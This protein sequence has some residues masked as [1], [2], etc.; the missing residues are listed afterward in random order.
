MELQ[1]FSKRIAITGALLILTIKYLLRPHWSFPEPVGF[2]LGIAPNLIASFLL[3]FF[4]CWLLSGKENLPARLF[5]I[6]HTA[7]L[8]NFCILSFLLLVINEYFQQLPVFG[9]TFDYFD[10]LFSLIGLLLS[11]FVFGRKMHQ[12]YRL[13]A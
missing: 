13:A 8:R 5:R 12:S 9:R 4:A 7:E 10:I 2:M 3:P 6:T 1:I 11:F